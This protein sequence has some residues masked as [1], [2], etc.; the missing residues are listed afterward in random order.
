[1]LVRLLD[2]DRLLLDIR[3]EARRGTNRCQTYLEDCPGVRDG[4]RKKLHQKEQKSAAY[5]S[6]GTVKWLKVW[7]LVME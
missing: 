5:L 2:K 6:R 7:I 1:M 3:A 4:L